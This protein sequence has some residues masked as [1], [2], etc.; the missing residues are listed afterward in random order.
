MKAVSEYLDEYCKRR[1]RKKKE[2]NNNRKLIFKGE[3]Q[4]LKGW[5][6]KYKRCVSCLFDN[7]TTDLRRVITTGDS[8]RFVE[9]CGDMWKFVEIYGDVWRFVELCADMWRC[10]EINQL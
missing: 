5:K 6:G 4:K 1:K 7:E 8:W 3:Y 2:Y 9:M 10:V